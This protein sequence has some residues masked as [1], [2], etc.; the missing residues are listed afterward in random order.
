MSSKKGQAAMEYLMTY[1]WALVALVVVI[2]ALM[3]TGAF[4]PSYLIAEECTLQPDL[5]CTGHVLYLDTSETPQLEF[6]I[7]NGLGYD[8]VLS[9]VNITTS[10]GDVYEDYSL[11]ISGDEIDQGE[12]A[13]VSM[14]LDGLPT[15]KD[16]VERFRVSLKYISCAPEVNPGCTEDEPEHVIS[17]RIVAHTAEEDA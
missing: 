10:N 8:I 1:G 17:G 5:S 16:E 15:H 9:G 3:A 4:N 13:I 7:S 14:E 2:A 6:R 12:T 11:D